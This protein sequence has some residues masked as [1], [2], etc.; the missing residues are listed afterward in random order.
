M[1]AFRSRCPK[2]VGAHSDGMPGSLRVGKKMVLNRRRKES[3]FVLLS[4]ARRRRKRMQIAGRTA[5]RRTTTNDVDSD[6][7]V[8]GGGRAQSPSD[9]GRH[10]N[11][12]MSLCLLAQKNPPQK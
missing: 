4:I 9:L 12:P 10:S 7:V 2:A 11:L 5:A 3:R 6:E 8:L 1:Y